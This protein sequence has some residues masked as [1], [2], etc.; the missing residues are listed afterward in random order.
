MSIWSAV[1]KIYGTVWAVNIVKSIGS[2]KKLK[3][4]GM[5]GIPKIKTPNFKKLKKKMN[6]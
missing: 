4:F 1:G 3:N 6:L 5:P 2:K